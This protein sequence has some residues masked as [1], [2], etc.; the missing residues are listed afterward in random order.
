MSTQRFNDGRRSLIAG[1]AASTVAA[2]TRA[3][4]QAPATEP[5]MQLANMPHSTNAT[6]TVER[7]DDIVL[8]GLNRPFIQNRLDP[9]T[10]VRLA[11][12]FWQCRDEN[13]AHRGCWRTRPSG[14]G[15][16]GP[17]RGGR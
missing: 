13:A 10:R 8:I 5:Q 2:V 6:I 11:E 14:G 4:A 17:W 15:R 1:V 3:H 12:V 9:P 7:Q 16:I